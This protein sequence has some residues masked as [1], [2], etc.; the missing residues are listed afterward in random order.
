VAAG[1]DSGP[2]DLDT[3]F[4]AATDRLDRIG[5]DHRDREP[6]DRLR[7]EREAD[8]VD[9]RGLSRAQPAS[10]AASIGAAPAQS[11]QEVR[12]RS[13]TAR[14]RSRGRGDEQRAGGEDGQSRSSTAALWWPREAG[15]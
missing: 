13:L 11:G 2:D 15:P 12:C 3:A 5:A 8:H 7:D 4:G 6:R 14:L 9:R 1:V 10:I